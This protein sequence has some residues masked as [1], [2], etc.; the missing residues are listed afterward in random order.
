MQTILDLRRMD[1]PCK[2]KKDNK[3]TVKLKT[4]LNYIMKGA[5][6]VVWR[7]CTASCCFCDCF[8]LRSIAWEHELVAAR[9]RLVQ[10]EAVACA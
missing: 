8:F 2:N 4:G 10:T 6:P 7:V 3:L 5:C 1:R 9:C